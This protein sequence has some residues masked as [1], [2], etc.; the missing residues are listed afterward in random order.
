MNA[1]TLEK[2]EYLVRVD[3][4]K[5]Y[6]RTMDG[7]V[8]AVDG[9]TLD[10][11]PGEA[12]GL[13]GES[14]CGKSVTAFSI[15]RLL[16]PKTSRIVQGQILFDRGDGGAPIDMAKVDPNGQL[17]RSIRGNDIAMIF[18]EPLTSLSPVHTVGSQIAEAVELHQNAR[19]E[20]A[21]QRA[22]E[23]LAAV[24]V[25]MPEQRF[26]EYPHQFSGGMRQRAMIAMALSC[27]PKLLIADEPTTALDVTIQ[28]QIL[29]LMKKLQKDMGMSILMITHNLGVIAEICS[30]VAV[31]YM[32]KVVETSDVR[33]IFR[34]PLHPYTVGLMRSI[35]HL[36]G[37]VK[38]RLTPIPGSVP[39][40]YSIPKG[41]A[42][43]PRCPA[44]RQGA[45]DMEVPLTEVEPGHQVRCILY[46]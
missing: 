20:Q 13:V 8:R 44:Y 35:P 39:D 23:M 37:K 9:V 41:C 21:R 45:C 5:T 34:N 6:F 15:M 2:Q 10:I 29:E 33:T 3:D 30:R 28:A 32:G 36:G 4:L 27:H 25:A 12:L 17:I 31:M 22:I 19:P 14:G 46:Q 42:F 26:T 7:T 38:D 43:S 24:G 40:P 16:P 11:R 18:Q 1:P